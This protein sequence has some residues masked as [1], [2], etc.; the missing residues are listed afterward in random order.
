M[1]DN[2]APVTSS[3]QRCQIRGLFPLILILILV[4]VIVPVLADESS[5]SRSTST[6]TKDALP[7]NIGL[8]EQLKSLAQQHGGG[9]IRVVHVQGQDREPAWMG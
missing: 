5:T 7:G 8:A 1:F 6:I 4:L 9:A 2:Y 3:P